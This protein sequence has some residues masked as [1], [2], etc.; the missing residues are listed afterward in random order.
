MTMTGELA[1]ADL[2]LWIAR[3]FPLQALQ[4]AAALADDLSVEAEI[5]AQAQRLIVDTLLIIRRTL[6]NADAPVSSRAEMQ[7]VLQQFLH[8]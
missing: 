7:A 8:S 4:V 1:A 6:A 2:S 3:K 5:R